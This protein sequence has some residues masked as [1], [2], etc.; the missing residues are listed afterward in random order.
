MPTCVKV[1]GDTPQCL[2]VV[3]SSRTSLRLAWDPYHLCSIPDGGYEMELTN[4]QTGECLVHHVGHELWI[5]VYGLASGSSYSARARA[6]GQAC[7]FNPSA[8]TCNTSS[9]K[10][11]FYYFLTVTDGL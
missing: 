3:K 7:P 9:V 8:C 5:E 1:L 2:R 6:I 4:Q 10:S 11:D